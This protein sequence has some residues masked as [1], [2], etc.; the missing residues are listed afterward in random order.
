MGKI[1]HLIIWK[2]DVI[3]MIDALCVFGTSEL[4]PL[5]DDRLYRLSIRYRTSNNGRFIEALMRLSKEGIEIR[6][7]EI[8]TIIFGKLEL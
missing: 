2:Q 3:R 7:P 6:K 4:V 8:R 1:A 5:K